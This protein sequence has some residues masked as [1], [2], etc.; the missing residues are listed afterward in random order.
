MASFVASVKKREWQ[1]SPQ[2]YFGDGKWMVS[3][4]TSPC[5][6]LFVGF[7]SFTQSRHAIV[8]LG[9]WVHCDGFLLSAA[10]SHLVLWGLTKDAAEPPHHCELGLPWRPLFF[11]PPAPSYWGTGNGG[12]GFLG[13]WA[14]L[15][16]IQVAK[17]CKEKSWH[18]TSSSER[19]R[20]F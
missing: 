3:V 13:I 8:R 2:E 14:S 16:C 15:H 4:P 9:A 17:P 10:L 20:E 18:A 19:K 12:A 11:S 7:F 1:S 6:W 5:L